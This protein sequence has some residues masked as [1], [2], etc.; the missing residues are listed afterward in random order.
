MPFHRVRDPARLQALIDAMLLVGGDLDI[1]A[2]LRTITQ[3]AV[4]LSGA[5]YG[6][7]GVLDASGTGLAEFITVGFTPE[8]TAAVGRL[9]EGKG[10]LGVLIKDPRPLRLDDIDDHPE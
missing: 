1:T 7:L 4:D 8:Q 2:V 6:A 10:V 9:P 3:T 5:R